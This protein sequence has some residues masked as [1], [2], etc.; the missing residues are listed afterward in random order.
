MEFSTTLFDVPSLCPNPR[1]SSFSEYNKPE[2]V[3]PQ[4]LSDMG[5]NEIVVSMGKEIEKFEEIRVK[6]P[7]VSYN[8]NFL[9]NVL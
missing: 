4:T 3:I 9:N 8:N 7:S 5:I 2:V 1:K 6:T